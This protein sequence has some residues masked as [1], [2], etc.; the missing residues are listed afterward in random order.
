MRDSP[1][2][3]LHRGV[4]IAAISPIFRFRQRLPSPS[5]VSKSAPNVG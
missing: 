3:A 1:R 2:I 5:W 4:I